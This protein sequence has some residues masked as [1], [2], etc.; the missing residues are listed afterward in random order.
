MPAGVEPASGL[1]FERDRELAVLDALLRDA[2]T[3][4][5]GAVV[6]E[7]QAGV[8]KTRLLRLA[9]Q[10]AGEAGFTVLRGRGSELE[11]AFGFGLVRQLLARTVAEAPE[12]LRRAPRGRRRRSGSCGRWSGSS[13]ISPRAGRWR[14]SP[15][16]CTGP[17]PRRCASSC[18]SPSART[19]SRWR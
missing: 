10:R 11:R 5:G 16:T 4:R 14:S 6:V 9:A 15:T 1:L 13:A 12:L 7:A 3:G 2:K 18:C 17:M 19:T 8:G